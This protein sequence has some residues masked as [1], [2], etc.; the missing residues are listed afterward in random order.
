MEPKGKCKCCS[1]DVKG[2]SRNDAVSFGVVDCLV[3]VHKRSHE[4]S[5]H[6][7]HGQHRLQLGLLLRSGVLA[8]DGGQCWDDETVPT[9]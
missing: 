9:V 4:Q 5:N 3:R 7:R 2:D 1:G 8:D 6:G